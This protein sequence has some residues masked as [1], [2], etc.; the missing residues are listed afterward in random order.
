MIPPSLSTRPS[1]R[2]RSTTSIPVS[3]E[4]PPRFSVEAAGRRLTVE[5][6]EGYPVGQVYAPAAEQFICF[7]P[8]T[9]P[10]NALVS[11]EGLRTAEPGQQ[12]TRK[13][14]GLARPLAG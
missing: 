11:G 10:T 6:G 2:A 13:L 4:P 7:E 9:A 12:R 3:R 8:M 14:L 5:C 1:A